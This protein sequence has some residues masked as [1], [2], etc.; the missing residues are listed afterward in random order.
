MA[1]S[2]MNRFILIL[3]FALLF[4]AA[5]SHTVSQQTRSLHPP[6]DPSQSEKPDTD[7]KFGLPESTRRAIYEDLLKIESNAKVLAK[8]RFPGRGALILTPEHPL[9]KK[10]EEVIQ[11]S[12]EIARREIA[13]MYSLT[14]E[15]VKEI[16]REGEEKLWTRPIPLPSIEEH[17]RR[18]DPGWSSPPVGPI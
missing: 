18:I 2:V 9:V 12:L 6:V 10:R 3:T 8:K 13:E 16:R 14:I 15:Q 5:C 17:W 7:E 11:S 4:T 1:V